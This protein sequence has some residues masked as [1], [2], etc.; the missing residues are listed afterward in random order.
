MRKSNIPKWMV[1]HEIDVMAPITTN[2]R[3]TVIGKSILLHNA[4]ETTV[5]INGNLTLVA[6]ATIQLNLNNDRE[7]YACTL[8]IGF[9][10][11]GSNRLEI[12]TS[13][14]IN[15]DYSNYNPQ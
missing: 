9:S 10:G 8:N 3:K 6:G 15:C 11:S 1:Q 2:Q 12:L 4:G 7:I 13:S 14:P 5:T